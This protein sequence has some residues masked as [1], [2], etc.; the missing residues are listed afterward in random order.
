[1]VR[2]SFGLLLCLMVLGGPL[3][4]APDGDDEFIVD[5]DTQLRLRPGFDAEILYS[6]P[7]S[8]GSWVAMAFDPQG[9]LIVSDQDDQ[10]V[11]RV[12]RRSARQVGK[13]GSGGQLSSYP[14]AL[15]ACDAGLTSQ[16]GNGFDVGI[17][18]GV[19]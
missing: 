8:Q 7:E 14:A 16:I 2:T 10:G 19:E 13:A 11:F 3:R 17:A 9:R 4:A 1:M 6:V 18:V 5:P 12:T 15:A